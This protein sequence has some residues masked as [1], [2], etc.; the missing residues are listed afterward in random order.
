MGRVGM[1][2]EDFLQLTPEEFEAVLA[3]YAR[4]REEQMHTGWEQARMIA[5]AAV[6]PHTSRLRGP[7]DLV[8]F[9][10]E[11]EET[12]ERLKAPKMTIEER[13]KLIDQLAA[14]WGQGM[15]D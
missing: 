1:S 3:Q 10:W 11:E 12:E 5:F 15:D 7:E 14:A 13:R 6:A 8:R 4:L 2:R 9:P